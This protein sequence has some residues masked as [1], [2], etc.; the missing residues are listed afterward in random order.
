VTE[1]QEKHKELFDGCWKNYKS[2]IVSIEDDDNHY[3]SVNG[4][5]LKIMGHII[6]ILRAALQDAPREIKINSMEML[7]NSLLEGDEGNTLC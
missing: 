1:L 2:F 3:T 5:N 6:C 7:T 4:T